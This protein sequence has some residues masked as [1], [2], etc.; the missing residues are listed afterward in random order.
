[1]STIDLLESPLATTAADH[2]QRGVFQSIVGLVRLWRARQK[3][4][5]ELAILDPHMLRD[6]GISREIVEFEARQPPWRPLRDWRDL[7]RGRGAVASGGLW[8]GGD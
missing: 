6:I 5:R 7:R 4:R 8:A 3:A 1:M 2:R